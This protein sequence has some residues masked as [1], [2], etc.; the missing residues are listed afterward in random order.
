MYTL[1]DA[2]NAY[3]HRGFG[4]MNKN[5][6]EVFIFNELLNTAPDFIGKSDFD[7]SCQLRI[8]QAKVKRL[9]YEAGLKYPRHQ[10]DMKTA[11]EQALHHTRILPKSD[12]CVEISV[13]DV[14]V[15]K[16][17]QAM[18]KKRNGF[19]DS[20]FN[21]EILRFTLEDYETILKEVYGEDA[22]KRMLQDVLKEIEKKSGKKE[23]LT[24]KDLLKKYIE[25]LADGAGHW[26]VDLALTALPKLL[27]S[28]F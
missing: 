10:S 12:R 25:G 18:L 24:F 9:R 11:I 2:I 5:D 16:N 21:S 8:P 19:C 7:I 26:I 1:Q 14:L 23:K 22:L 17:I 15:Q 3:L 13:E 4:S 6:F 20:S 27:I 28:L